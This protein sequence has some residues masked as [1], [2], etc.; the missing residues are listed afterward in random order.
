[1]IT[2]KI[3]NIEQEVPE[4]TTILDAAKSAG[5]SV[6]TLCYKEGLPHYSSCM[7]CLVKDNKSKGFIP[8]CSA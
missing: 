8:S 5:I 7:V 2:I 6:P 3:D 1:M 4:G